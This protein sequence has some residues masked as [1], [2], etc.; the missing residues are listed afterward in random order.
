MP[1]KKADLIHPGSRVRVAD[2]TAAG[3]DRWTNALLGTVAMIR[4]Q[5]QGKGVLVLLDG[6]SKPEFHLWADVDV[7]QKPRPQLLDLP[8]VQIH[9]SRWQYRRR[10][11]I[12]ALH[13]LAKSIQDHG[14]VNRLLVFQDEDGGYEL[15]AGERRLRACWALAMVRAQ[16]HGALSDAVAAVSAAGWWQA[17]PV[18]AIDHA[19]TV[20]VEL[21]SGA[22]ADFREIVIVENMIRADPTA[23]EEA[24]A[25][26]LLITEEGYTQERLAARLGKSQGYISQRLGLLG[27]ADEVRATVESAE[28]SFTAARAIATL[29]AAVQAPV[30]ELV[31]KMAAIEGDSAATSRKVQAMAAQ[32]RKFL[33]PA[34]WADPPGVLR[35]HVRNRLWLARQL[36]EHLPPERAGDILKLRHDDQSWEKSYLGMKPESL[37]AQYKFDEV[38]RTLTGG[39]T[40]E[41]AWEREAKANGHTCAECIF[42]VIAAPASTFDGY[43]RRW[44]FPD[45]ITSDVCFTAFFDPVVIPIGDTPIRFAKALDLPGITYDPFPHCTVI[46][47]WLDI[48]ARAGDAQRAEFAARDARRRQQHV[49]PLR[50]YWQAQN[51]LPWG[52]MPNL[53]SFQ[54]HA[55]CRCYNYRQ[56]QLAD[57]LPPCRLAVEPLKERWGDGTAAPDMGVLIRDDGAM[58]PRCSEFRVA[59]LPEIT[60]LDGFTV[61][62]QS[63]ARKSVIAWLERICRVGYQ[64][65]THNGTVR[66]PLAWLPYDRP[67]DVNGNPEAVARYVNRHWDDIGDGGVAHLLDIAL[68]EARATGKYQEPIRLLDADTGAEGDWCSVT[69]GAFVAGKDS[70]RYSSSKAPG[71]WPKPW[72]GAA[73]PELLPDEEAA[74]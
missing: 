24:E 73:R 13:E 47:T 43:C 61:K 34:H 31:Q 49:H 9:P 16:R 54:A 59:E 2:V 69:W 10:W 5:D 1:K 62:P 21:R 51:I 56:D 12:E 8:V 32:V 39:L 41:A 67:D 46:D 15:I 17:P 55:C 40:L 45:T 33:D 4:K 60:P 48:Q 63:Y 50:E 20:P 23:I 44:Q 38:V 6:E 30:T 27:L 37:V 25:F 68:A 66:S 53:G 3:D 72:I 29:P 36:I 22:A 70:D 74:Q 18:L 11:D 26:N 58:V 42:R 28:I 65:H 64:N 7:E 14:L 35:P 52:L 71:D 57:K 19:E